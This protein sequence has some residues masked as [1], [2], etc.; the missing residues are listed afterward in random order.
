MAN[1]VNTKQDLLPDPENDSIQVI[2][3]C[4]QT[5]DRNISS[6]G[7][8]QG[9]HIGIIALNDFDIT[10]IGISTSREYMCYEYI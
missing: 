10:K 9:Y 3:Y 1:V 4:L 5:D 7:Y 6:N 8:K 2:F